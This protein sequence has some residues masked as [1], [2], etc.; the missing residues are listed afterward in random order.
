VRFAIADPPY[1]PFVGSG[2]RKNRAS[3]WYGH[4]QRSVTDRPADFHAD[5][6]QWDDPARHQK[7]VAE[8][9]D[10]YDGWAIATCPDGLAAYHPIPAAC[11]IMVWVKPNA[12]PGANRI[13]NIWEPVIV[14]PA[15]GRRSNRHRVGAVPDVLTCNVPRAGFRGAKPDAWTHWILRA[16]SYWPPTDSCEDLFC[17]S[18]LV[19]D[20][21]KVFETNYV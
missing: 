10:S 21:I 14:Y 11:R 18:G 6:Q 5:A 7:L 13:R 19:A 12:Q 9:L 3:R 1:P 20:A 4:G 16:L 17:G 8:L 2:G 15:A